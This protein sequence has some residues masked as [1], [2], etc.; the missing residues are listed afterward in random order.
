MT[1]DDNTY[2]AMI[3]KIAAAAE[4]A[5]QSHSRDLKRTIEEVKGSS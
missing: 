4:F 2:K 1:P 5:A 3:Q